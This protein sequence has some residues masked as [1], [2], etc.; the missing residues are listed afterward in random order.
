MTVKIVKAEQQQHR[1]DHESDMALL[2]AEHDSAAAL[3]G[4]VQRLEPVEVVGIRVFRL[5]V[6]RQIGATLEQHP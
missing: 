2:K 1:K 6:Q 5:P 3:V 4:D